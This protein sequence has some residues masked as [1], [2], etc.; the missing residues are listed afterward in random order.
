MEHVRFI[1]MGIVVNHGLNP[2]GEA[3]R[4]VNHGAQVLNGQV[5]WFPLDGEQSAFFSVEPCESTLKG[6]ILQT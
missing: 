6:G 4:N 3:Q 1:C 5:C 2:L